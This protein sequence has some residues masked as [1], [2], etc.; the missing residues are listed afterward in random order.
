[1]KDIGSRYNIY[2]NKWS[3]KVGWE[4]FP[5]LMQMAIEGQAPIT[6]GELADQA[7]EAG[8]EFKTK[9]KGRRALCMNYPLGCVL[10]TLFEY[11]EKSGIDIPYLTTIIVN[12]DTRQPTYFSKGQGWSDDKIQAEQTAVYNF[13]HWAHIRQA[14]LQEENEDTEN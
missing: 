1:M 2:G 9:H 13:K 12:K 14:I 6:Y 5:I 7:E 4:I 3:Q 11:Q 10:K 8:I